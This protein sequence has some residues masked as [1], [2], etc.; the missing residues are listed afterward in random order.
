MSAGEMLMY[1]FSAAYGNRVKVRGGVARRVILRGGVAGVGGVH[2][3]ETSVQ[4]GV[5]KA[6]AAEE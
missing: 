1:V 2:E 3:F 4:P 5:L 6:R